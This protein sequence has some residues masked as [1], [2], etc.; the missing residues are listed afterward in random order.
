MRVH[1]VETSFQKIAEFL[2][3]AVTDRVTDRDWSRRVAAARD[4]GCANDI[5]LAQLRLDSSYHLRARTSH[6]LLLYPHTTRY[7]G[8]QPAVP[9]V[10]SGTPP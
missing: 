2:Y 4:S 1:S 10:A 8:L 5:I 3:L 7:P 6:P 9:W